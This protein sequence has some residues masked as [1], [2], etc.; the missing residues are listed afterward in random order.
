[1]AEETTVPHIVFSTVFSAK[2]GGFGR[3]AA[4]A[5]RF[6]A[7]AFSQPESRSTSRCGPGVA[8]VTE[9][10]DL[11]SVFRPSGGPYKESQ[12]NGS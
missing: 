3:R 2:G 11:D 10:F 6:R 1:M 7:F 5:S 9:R 4:T 12:S 8:R